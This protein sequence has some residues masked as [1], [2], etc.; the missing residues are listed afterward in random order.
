MRKI[1]DEWF[2]R[3]YGHPILALEY[4]KKS[5][6]M[7]ATVE[8]QPEQRSQSSETEN[9]WPGLYAA[10]GEVI[11]AYR[12]KKKKF[13]SYEA[14]LTELQALEDNQG[15]KLFVKDSGAKLPMSILRHRL[16]P[17]QII[18]QAKGQASLKNVKNDRRNGGLSL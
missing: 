14:L 4:D 3:H 15:R 8:Y 6:N 13:I 18:R 1:V 7:V 12:S 17:S 2:Q 9:S 16:A 10:I 11:E 5:G